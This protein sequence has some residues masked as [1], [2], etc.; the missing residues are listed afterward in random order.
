MAIPSRSSAARRPT[1]GIVSSW[2]RDYGKYVPAW[3]KAVEAL[4]IQ[5]DV[6]IA[7]ECVDY[8]GMGKARNEVIAQC[9]TDWVVYLDIDDR[10]LP[11]AIADTVPY[12][13]TADVVVWNYI[14]RGGARDGQVRAF[15]NSGSY[16]ALLVGAVAM[17][18]SPFRK[19]LWEAAP[20]LEIPET[21]AGIDTAVDTF[22]WIGFHKQKA[23]FRNIKG[24]QMEYVIH[25]DSMMHSKSSTQNQLAFAFSQL[26]IERE[27]KAA[28]RGNGDR[29]L[30]V[31][32]WVH[33]EATASARELG[34]PVRDLI[35]HVWSRHKSGR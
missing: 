33:R 1:F 15:F 8:T 11:N 34:V 21:S 17:S 20:Y 2:W 25:H 31:P 6:V 5:P 12:L 14:E 7:Q 10:I 29:L 13:H 16:N 30:S 35:E 28:R 27:D 23:L 19:S 9:D 32:Q 26:L 3:H 4:T 22:L 24:V 18:S